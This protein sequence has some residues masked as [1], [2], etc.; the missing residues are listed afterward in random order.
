MHLGPV[1]AAGDGVSGQPGPLDPGVAGRRVRR[2]DPGR[3]PGCPAHRRRGAGAGRP[4]KRE[5]PARTAAHIAR[6][7]E[8]RARVGAVGAHPAAPLRP[9][10]AEHPPRR[11]AAEGVR[12]VRGRRRA[13]SCGSATGCTARSSRASGRCCSRCSTTT[14]AM[15]SGTAGGTA[16]TPWACRPR[17][18]TRS[19]PTAA[20]SGCTATTAPPTPHISWPG[21]RRCWTSSWCTAG[22]ENRRDVGKIERWNR[23]VRDQFLVEVDPRRRR[24]PCSRWPSSTGCSPPGATSSTTAA[25]TPKPAPPRRSVTTP[26]TAP[27]RPQPDPAL[28]RRAFLWREQRKVT[29]FATVS[30]HG[31]R[32][33][34][35]AALVGRTVDLLFT[36]FDLTVIEVEYQGRPMGHAA[37]HRIGRHIHPAV[38]PVATAPADATGIDYLRLLDDAHQKRG[39]PGDQLPRPHRQQQPG[40]Q[41]LR[42]RTAYRKHA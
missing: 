29:A 17:C 10:G 15:W 12:P 37:P 19:R 38:K 33:E 32:Y 1:R 9:P 16:R 39:R 20:H 8:H 42:R 5:R 11:H 21:R 22:P 4:A 36:P 14:P 18:T 3:T 31:N 27:G 40:S 41:L 7:I 35:D 23:T 13:T 25:C 26:R 2:P 24:V 28:L 6:I 30:L 34:V